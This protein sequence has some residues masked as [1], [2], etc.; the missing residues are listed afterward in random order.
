[1][2]ELD[3]RKYFPQLEKAD[4]AIYLDSGA[5]TLKP[6]S[7]IKRMNHSYS[8]ETSNIHRGSYALGE[9][10]TCDFEHSRLAVRDFIKAKHA[11]EI[12]FTKGTTESINLV[13]SSFGELLSEGDEIIL[14]VMEHHSNL[15]PWQMLAKRKKLKI[16]YVQMTDNNTLDLDHYRSLLSS[17]TK[18]VSVTHISNVLGTINPIARMTEMAHDV[19]A[20]VLI[21]AAQSIAHI[22]VDVSKLDV[23]FLAF[24]A[25]K[26]YG[27]TGLGVLY[28]KEKILEEMPPYQ[29]GGSMIDQVTLAGTSFNELPFKFEAG[30]PAIAQVLAFHESLKFINEVG[31]E[32]IIAHEQE[33]LKYARTMLS[34]IDG[35]KLFLPTGESAATISFI[36]DGVHHYDIG[37]FLSNYKVAI[38]TGH[39]CAQPLMRELG[40]SGT[41]RISLGC[42]NN[43]KDLEMFKDA[44]NKT[45]KRL[46]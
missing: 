38:R 23:D 45:L 42:Y 40:V 33:L 39:H 30:T 46:K 10:V 37:S 6:I 27:P 13:A 9:R 11:H 20:K 3:C 16:H 36:V 5:T 15:V 2:K 28:G 17:K 21:D 7:V 32:N 44:L 18:L 41:N 19:G 14:T 31:F 29:F 24:S 25:H 1:M 34:E 22:P 43:I 26:A 4:T 8:L 35:V 12:I